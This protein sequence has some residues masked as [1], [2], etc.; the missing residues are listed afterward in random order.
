MWG[1]WPGT[2]ALEQMP[3]GGVQET[4]L[5]DRAGTTFDRRDRLREKGVLF[6]FAARRNARFSFHAE[7]QFPYQAA[8]LRSYFEQ[9]TGG[10][11]VAA[12]SR[13]TASRTAAVFDFI[14]APRD[15]RKTD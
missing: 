14:A 10:G 13:L 3:A 11:R 15:G 6:T 4:R 9:E 5:L 12:R 2:G 7:P 1:G 8:S